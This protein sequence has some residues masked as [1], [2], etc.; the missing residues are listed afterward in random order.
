MGI[1]PTVFWGRQ[2]GEIREGA[3]TR[4]DPDWLEIDYALIVLLDE[5]EQSLCVCGEP[6]A[7]HK[8]KTAE[9]YGGAFLTCPAIEALDAEQAKLA[10]R[11]G[12]KDAKP[13]PS[14]ARAWF[15]RTLDQLRA[16]ADA[17][18]AEKQATQHD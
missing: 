14:R 16:M 3:F 15:T 9:D 18:L 5:Y 7:S 8:G 6:V 12:Q 11:E 2:R 4:H 13:D 17:D 10:K 1:A